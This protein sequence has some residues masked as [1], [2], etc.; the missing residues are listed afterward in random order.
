[1]QV[2][3]E[4]LV[5][6]NSVLQV[7][8]TDHDKVFLCCS[9]ID[10][11]DDTN[12]KRDFIYEF[13][14]K[15]KNMKSVFQIDELI[16]VM[17]QHT[18]EISKIYNMEYHYFLRGTQCCTSYYERLE[19]GNPVTQISVESSNVTPVFIKTNLPRK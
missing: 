3:K 12:R 5:N 13:T 17:N 14:K 1:M 7:V 16:I 2:L 6:E 11:D 9:Y 10:I 19:N 15:N 18:K 8:K 4:E